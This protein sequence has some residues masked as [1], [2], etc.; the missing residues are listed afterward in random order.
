MPTNPVI[1]LKARLNKPPILNP[2][3]SEEG[4]GVCR[5]GVMGSGTPDW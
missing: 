2:P 5:V 4:V 1:L 3:T